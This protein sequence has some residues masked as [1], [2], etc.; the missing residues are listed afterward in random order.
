MYT[1]TEIANFALGMLGQS[2]EIVNVDTETTIQA[3]ILRRHFSK[4]V[5]ETLK[6]EWNVLTKTGALSL[7][8]ED[9]SPKWQYSYSKPSDAEVVRRIESDNY[10]PADRQYEDQKVPFDLM[11]TTSGYEIHTNIPDAYAE[12]T[13]RPADVGPYPDHVAWA[14]A[15][16]LAMIAAPQIITNNYVKIKDTFLKEARNTISAQIAYDIT[17]RPEP[18]AADSPFIRARSKG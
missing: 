17:L 5:V 2:L 10:F 16:N 7:I 4:A 18:I 11:Y 14:I 12:Y 15:A 3:K 8:A 13:V 1:K 9:P 6:Y